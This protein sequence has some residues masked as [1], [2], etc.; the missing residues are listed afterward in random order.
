M[1]CTLLRSH[2]GYILGPHDRIF[3][4]DAVV[5]LGSESP[6]PHLNTLSWKSWLHAPMRAW[7]RVASAFTKTTATVISS[8]GISQLQ[9]TLAL[10]LQAYDFV[11]HD[12]FTGGSVPPGLFTTTLLKKIHD[13]VLRPG[14]DLP[15]PVR[16]LCLSHSLQLTCALKS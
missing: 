8:R 1:T 9:G 6:G 11:L 16:S 15:S 10:G 14:G 3:V 7:N 12:M 13:V 2:F 5:L 4:T